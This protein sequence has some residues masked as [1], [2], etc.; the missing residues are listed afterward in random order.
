MPQNWRGRDSVIAVL[1][2]KLRFPPPPHPVAS[3]AVSSKE[4]VLVMFHCFCYS[5]FLGG[6]LC[7]VILCPFPFIDIVLI[8]CADPERGQGVRTSF[9]IHKN[10]GFL[11]NTGPD[12]LKN[13]KSTKP[14]F[15]VGSSSARQ[16]NAI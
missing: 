4:M 14:A 8:S 10:T 16:R 6:F 7:Y 15:N 3:A 12:P 5:H 13:H 1:N 9:K 11:S 2:L